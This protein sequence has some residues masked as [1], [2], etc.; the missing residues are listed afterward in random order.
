MAPLEIL[1][2]GGGIAGPA[3]AFWLSRLGH[4][5]TVIE[6]H[7]ELRLGGQQIDIREQGVTVARRMGLLEDIRRRSVDELG[8]AFV[9]RRGRR[10]AFFGR[11]GDEERQSFTSEFEI[12]RGDLCSILHDASAGDGVV[13]RFGITVDDY[14]HVKDGRRVSVTFSDGSVAEYDLV[15]GADGQGSRVRRKM[16]PQD[17][18]RAL[19]V[20]CCYF[21]TSRQPED[22]E[23]VFTLY[24]PG[25]KRVV[26]TR[27]HSPDAGQGYLMTRSHADEMRRVL[28]QDTAAQRALFARIFSGAGWQSDRL[29]REMHE[30]RDIYAFEAVQVTANPWSRGR[31]VLLGDAA[32]AP[33]FFT[34]MGTS[35]AL[36]GAYVLAGEL[37]THG[38]DVEAG[39]AAYDAR[40]RSFVEGT[41]K[42]S[43]GVPAAMFPDTWWGVRIFQFILTIMSLI[44]IDN[45]VGLIFKYLKSDAN[46]WQVPDYPMLASEKNHIM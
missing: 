26:A 25:R 4:T 19:G 12:M 40:L 9:D 14:H 21:N 22:T 5:C 3:A 43:P 10:F 1:I 24:Q 41:Q 7:P 36:V 11:S 17:K 30:A 34:G 42:L 32:H 16:V 15:I 45:I 33:S 39:L 29:V 28:R 8:T 6:R 23:N 27:W 38:H 31:V 18:Y 44:R 20:F 13:W 2:C 37:S 46:Q 35:L